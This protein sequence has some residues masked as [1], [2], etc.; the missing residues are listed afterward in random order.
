MQVARNEQYVANRRRLRAR[1]SLLAFSL[2]IVVLVL[3]FFFE[4]SF[5]FLWP[6]FFIVFVATNASKQLQFEW[7][8][9]LLADERLAQALKVLNNRYW[10]GAYIPIGRYVVNHLLIGP[11]G[12]LVIETRNHPGE[13]R[14]QNGRWSRK[15][16]SL[17]RIFG[18]IPPV[19]NPSRD[20]DA[21]VSAV[22]KE[23][24]SAGLGKVPVSGAVVFTAPDANIELTDCPTTTL[25]LT[26]LEAWAAGRRS[27]AVEVV[28]DATRQK[29]I[30]HFADL[31]PRAQVAGSTSSRR[32]TR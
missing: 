23:I 29:L 31:M 1:V 21:A 11:E 16:G 4:Q 25:T 9:G 24:E 19:G 26:Q 17:S 32:S 28:N 14:C 27:S 3:P 7:G 8:A 5:V 10:F 20:L 13:I 22:D 18:P 6:L 15:G 30:Q 2:L 12:V